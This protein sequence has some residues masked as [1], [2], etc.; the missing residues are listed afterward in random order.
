VQALE[1]ELAQLEIGTGKVMDGGQRL[2][3]V[4]RELREDMA[5]AI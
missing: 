3:I 4:R 1:L 5:Q 2:G